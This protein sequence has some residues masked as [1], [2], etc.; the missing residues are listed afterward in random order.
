MFGVV[1]GLLFFDFG[2]SEASSDF[3][4]RNM[5]RSPQLI[6]VY[7]KDRWI[8]KKERV[9]Q[10]NHQTPHVAGTSFITCSN[11]FISK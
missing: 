7:C 2:I 1:Q 5:S 6:E 8:G 11:V 3:Q 10:L 4:N 9:N